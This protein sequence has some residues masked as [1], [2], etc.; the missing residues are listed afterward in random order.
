MYLHRIS[1]D[2]GTRVYTTN[3]YRLKATASR[4]W[5]Q[6]AKDVAYPPRSKLRIEFIK[7]S[8]LNWLRGKIDE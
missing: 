1:I 8:L 2:C 5:D 4:V 6:M 7:V 3:P